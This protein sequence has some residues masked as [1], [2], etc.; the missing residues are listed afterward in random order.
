[1]ELIEFSKREK[2]GKSSKTIRKDGLV[3]CV[4]Y[5]AK[6]E[7]FSVA[8]SYKIA[9]ALL[10]SATSTTIFDAK[11]EDKN[12]KVVLK[13]VDR[14]PLTSEVI[15]L[16]FFQIDENKPMLFSI[17]FN[18]IGI[19]PAVKNNLGILVKALSS[20]EVR[21]KLV[22]LVPQIDIDISVLEHPG[23]TISVSDI[24]L[25]EGMALPN[26]EQAKSAIVTVTQLQKVEEVVPVE[27]VTEEG[28]D[29]TTT[30]EGET[31]TEETTE[32]K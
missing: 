26:D 24:A 12:M 8:M 17:P 15:H 2:L 23:Q 31:A 6:A 13:D 3:P 27:E 7:S 28:V 21:C 20:I 32:K 19:S 18:I 10:G 30:N 25:P 22:D 4:I 5:N 11:L 14:S 9:E 16:S 29:A 1:M